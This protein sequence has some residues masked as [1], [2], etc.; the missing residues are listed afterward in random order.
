ME[1]LLEAQHEL[2]AL[3]QVC[4]GGPPVKR[5]TFGAVGRRLRAIQKSAARAGLATETPRG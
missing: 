2:L 4:V 5:P 1:Q 3:V